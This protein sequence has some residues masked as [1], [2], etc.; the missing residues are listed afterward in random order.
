MQRIPLVN[1]AE[2]TAAQRPVYERIFHGLGSPLVGPLR[3][4]LHIPELADR[5]QNLGQYWQHHTVLTPRQKEVAVLV[6]ARR[7][8]AQVEWFQHE[9]RARKAGLEDA[10]IE[11]I[12]T[13]GVPPFA[14]AGERA[15]YD[16]A[17]ELQAGG[18][19]A[20]AT[21]AAALA[22]LGRDALVDVTALVGFYTMVAMMLN[23]HGI[24]MLEDA[25]PPLAMP[26]GGGLS[27]LPAAAG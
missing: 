12:R 22:A 17:R 6:T 9:Q 5:W 14:D 18:A 19:V 4:V 8:N 3:A 2:L 15:I 25:P 11:A 26:A 1:P 7:W 24:A 16:Y 20:D 21:Y 23:A 10:L 27:A 13:G